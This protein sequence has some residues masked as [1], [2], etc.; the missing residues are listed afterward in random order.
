MTLIVQKK[1]SKVNLTCLTLTHPLSKLNANIIG[2]LKLSVLNCI[3]AKVSAQV[4]L[5]NEA[6]SLL[7]STSCVLYGFLANHFGA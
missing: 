2:G 1:K 5:N 6:H 3:K 7:S 4:L